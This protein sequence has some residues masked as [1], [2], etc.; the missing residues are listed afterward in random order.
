M[1]CAPAFAEAQDGGID[2]GPLVIEGS[3]WPMLPPDAGSVGVRT[4]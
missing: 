1:A 2:R 4:W 3:V